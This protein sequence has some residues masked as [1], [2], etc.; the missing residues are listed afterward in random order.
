[1][2]LQAVGLHL[3]CRHRVLLGL[4]AEALRAARPCARRAAR[5]CPA[6]CRSAPHQ[7]LQE[8]HFLVEVRVDP[9]VELVVVGHVSGLGFRGEVGRAAREGFDGQ[10]DVVVG[11]RF[12]R[13]VADAGVLAA[14]EQ[15][16]LRHHLVQLHRVV[17]GA[18]GHAVQRHAERVDRALPALLPLGRARRGGGAHRLLERV[19]ARRAARRSRCS[20]ASTSSRQR[21]A[22]R[23]RS[24][25]AGRG[26]NWQRPGHHVDRAVRHVAAC[27]SCRPSR[28]PRAARCST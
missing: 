13:V 6:A 18:A 26:V 15:H 27:R 10:L 25:R 5:C 19:A 8:A 21:V 4:E 24:S 9:G 11:A 20:S 7:L 1:M 17:A 12:E 22:L 14:H 2:R 3:A 23:R 28:G 16:G